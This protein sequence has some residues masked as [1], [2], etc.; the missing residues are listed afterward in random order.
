MQNPSMNAFGRPSTFASATAKRMEKKTT[1]RTSFCAAASKKRLISWH[2][3][4]RKK[5]SS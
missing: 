1:C 3:K 2:L 4:L 5:R